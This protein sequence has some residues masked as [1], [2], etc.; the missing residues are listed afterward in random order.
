MIDDPSEV[1]LYEAAPIVGSTFVTA[2]GTGHGTLERASETCRLG[3]VEVVH[4][5]PDR[6]EDPGSDHQHPE[7][8]TRRFSTTIPGQTR[9]MEVGRRYRRRPA[10]RLELQKPYRSR[11]V[12]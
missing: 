1:D 3:V 6:L 12:S 11:G 2:G 9:E 7:E 4:G 10:A 8:Q 5:V